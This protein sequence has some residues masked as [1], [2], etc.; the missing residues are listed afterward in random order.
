VETYLSSIN[1]TLP[2]SLHKVAS[3]L[4]EKDKVS[5]SHFI[6]IAVAEKISALLTEDY[7]KKRTKNAPSRKEI[8]KLLAKVQDV[9]PEEYD[10]F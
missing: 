3:E 9:E 7:L 6:S 5:I 1:I 2:E 8:E 4:A 10:R